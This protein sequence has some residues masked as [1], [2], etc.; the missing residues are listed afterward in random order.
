MTQLIQEL[1]PNHVQQIKWI[2]EQQQMDV[3]FSNKIIFSNEIHFHFDGLFNRQ[4]CR[5]RKSTNDC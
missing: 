5:G 2:M 1:K 4:N 3:D